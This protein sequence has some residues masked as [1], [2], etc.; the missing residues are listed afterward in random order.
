MV[1]GGDVNRISLEVKERVIAR[2]KRR[3]C[4][5]NRY[6]AAHRVMYVAVLD[7]T[8]PLEDRNLAAICSECEQKHN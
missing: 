5:C 3:C 2:D 7:P 8:K 6:F 4:R 1:E